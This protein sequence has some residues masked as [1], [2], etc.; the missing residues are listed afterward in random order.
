MGTLRWRRL[1]VSI[2]SARK[3]SSKCPQSKPKVWQKLGLSILQACGKSA[4]ANCRCLQCL[5]SSKAAVLPLQH[6]CATCTASNFCRSKAFHFSCIPNHLL[7]ATIQASLFRL[8]N[9]V[10]DM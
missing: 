2:L 6:Q 8:L 10:G 7:W 4:K 9:F 5:L 1:K 3:D